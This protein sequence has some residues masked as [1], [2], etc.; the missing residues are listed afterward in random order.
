MQH[1]V[2]LTHTHPPLHS[3]KH[4]RTDAVLLADTVPDD[5]DGDCGVDDGVCDAGDRDAEGVLG[6]DVGV[7]EGEEEM[8]GSGEAWRVGGRHTAHERPD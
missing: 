4:T 1:P 6:D 2:R 3:R 8:L 7:E 5:G